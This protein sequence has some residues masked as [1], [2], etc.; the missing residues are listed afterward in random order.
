MTAAGA[1]RARLCVPRA[2]SELHWCWAG[3]SAASDSAHEFWAVDHH[4]DHM[5]VVNGRPSVVRKIQSGRPDVLGKPP[6]ASECLNCQ[7]PREVHD[8]TM[9]HELVS[10]VALWVSFYDQSLIV[11]VGSLMDTGTPVWPYHCMERNTNMSK[12]S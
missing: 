4:G 12:Y 1:T 8:D 5:S 6:V 7:C 10:L 11:G 9:T 3:A 2:G